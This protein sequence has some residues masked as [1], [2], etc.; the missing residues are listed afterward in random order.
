MA[1]DRLTLAPLLHPTTELPMAAER[2][3]FWAPLLIATAAALLFS[4]VAVPRIDVDGAAS[5]AIDRDP[6]AAQM[7]PHERETKIEQ[8]RKVTA[9]SFYAGSAFGTGLT[10]L[11]AAL[12]LW[13]GFRV[14]G[15]RPAFAPTFT[16]TAWSLLPG[17]LAALLAIPAVL[18]RGTVP[19]EQLPTLLPSS[20][21][22]LLPP[23]ANPQLAA[24]LGAVDLFSLWA[25]WMVA[26]GMAGVARFTLRRS[27][28][29]VF[30]LWASYVAV[31]RVAL[32]AL[33][34][35]R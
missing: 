5:E 20:L 4:I 26:A 9:L 28:V 11:L 23:G 2:R 25:L 1:V 19:V 33:Q 24:L 14:A 13:T 21:A 32:I 16:V 15:G 35:P 8:A 10:A 34:G 7:T 29:T 12:G 30:V 22:V 18:V 17:A 3:L 31:F 6:G 27:I